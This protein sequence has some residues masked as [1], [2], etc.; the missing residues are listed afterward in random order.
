MITVRQQITAL[1]YKPT[2]TR[3]KKKRRRSVQLRFFVA[4]LLGEHLAIREPLEGERMFEPSVG[5]LIF[6]LRERKPI[7][8]N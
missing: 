3:S 7:N 8:K 1:D 5:S 6:Y 2:P 4:E